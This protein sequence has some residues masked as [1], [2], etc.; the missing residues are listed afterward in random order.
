MERHDSGILKN[1]FIDQG[2]IQSQVEAAVS[3]AMEQW[4]LNQIVTEGASVTLPD[5]NQDITLNLLTGGAA[6]N[7]VTVNLPSNTD[8]R[9]GQRVFVNSNGN[10]ADVTFTSTN[11]VNN[12]DVAF[13]PGDNFV[14]YRNQPTIWSRITS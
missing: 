5:T 14:Y 11:T 3:A 8:G 6:L 9:I 1:G 7:A 10:I 4:T 2:D 12:S 13:S